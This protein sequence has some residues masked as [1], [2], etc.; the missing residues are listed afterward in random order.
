MKYYSRIILAQQRFGFGAALANSLQSYTLS[1]Q[2]ETVPYKHDALAGLTPTNDIIIEMGHFQQKRRK[3]KKKQ[4]EKQKI[5]Q[6]EN[7]F[8]K[9][10]YNEQIHAR[11]LQ[12]LHSPLDFQERLIQFW[13]NHFAIS[14]DKR[15]IRPLAAT[16]ENDIVRKYWN[17]NFKD[18]LMGSIK[19]PAMLI[20]LDNNLS[21]GPHSKV[22]K[23]RNKGLN[24]NLAREIM[25]LHTLGVNGGYSQTDVT[26]LAKAITGW[27]VSFNENQPG[28]AFNFSMH[29]PGSISL[30]NKS[31]PQAGIKQG[32]AC[33]NDL[34]L[35][36]STANYIAAKLALHFAGDGQQDL[37]EKLSSAFLKHKGELKP[38][39]HILINHPACLVETPVRFRT[40]QEWF[41]AVL[42]S[43]GMEPT[44]KQMRNMLDRLGQTPF[45]AGSPAG[46]SD[47][48]R[49]Y[50]SPSA[51]VQRWQIA[52]V[53]A[54]MAV[55]HAKSE[56][57]KPL[58]LFSDV[59]T[60]LYGDYLDQ[61]TEV[62]T[63]KAESV[64]SKLSLLWLSPQFQYR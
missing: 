18:M 19:H 1:A 6:Q 15:K 29:E 9:Q 62:A 60:T 47:Y 58:S 34:A 22:G 17:G 38:L 21:I 40:P 46:W 30:L 52:N 49:D 24:E 28:F 57:K 59:R 25:E 45:M 5:Q 31:Y 55:K 44:G 37:V 13:S 64:A 35:H 41:F 26:S 61:H 4:A 51:L 43:V 36:L 16:I 54:A 48:D 42:R 33:L 10:Q 39:Y 50:N 7:T 27:T 63:N 53:I 8:S 20:F 11:N 14:V 56:G 3:S 2:V 32:E 23:K 12:T